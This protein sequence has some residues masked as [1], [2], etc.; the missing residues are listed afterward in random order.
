MDSSPARPNGPPAPIAGT[1]RPAST[2]LPAFEPLSSSPALPR[3]IKRLARVSPAEHEAQ[4]LKYPTPVPT[5]STGILSSS[6]PALSRARPAFHRTASSVSERAP[7]SAVPSISLPENGEP[8]LMGRSSN[9]SHYQLSANRLISRVHVR[10]TYL[11]TSNLLTPNKVEIVCM[12]WN[13][14][15]VHCQGRTWDLAKGDSFTSESEHDVMLDAQDSRVLITWPS[16]ARKGS[17]AQSDATWD[18]ENSPKSA[19]RGLSSRA[20]VLGTS[21]LRQREGLHSPE[22]PTPAGNIPSPES[23]LSKPLGGSVLGNPVVVYEDE[24]PEEEVEGEPTQSTQHVSQANPKVPEESEADKV[25]EFSDQDE[26]ND[27]II[28]AFGPQGDNI[29]PLMASCTTGDGVEG[30]AAAESKD[31]ATAA[32]GAS[33]HRSSSEST[34]A[35]PPSTIVNHIVNQLAFSRLSSTPLSSILSN[36]PLELRNTSSPGNEN[37]SEPMTTECLRQI[38]HTAPCI[39]EVSREGKDAAGRLLESEFY[40]LPDLDTDEKRRDAVV[41]GL[42]KPGLRN[43]RKQHKQYYWRKPKKA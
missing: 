22:S 34:R 41:D 35:A 33:P 27:P 25:E 18:E 29:L 16:A 3:P 12:G 26:E 14:V 40:Y 13:G 10:A 23:P 6:P 9:S 11:A 24:H 31:S 8:V 30:G 38:L 19:N 21:P 37:A 15:K 7:L 28:Q 1:K 17:S 43:C 5:S 42:R 39:G 36:L 32:E 2:L 4:I 20:R